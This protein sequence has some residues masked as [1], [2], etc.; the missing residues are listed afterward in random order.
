M[1]NLSVNSIFSLTTKRVADLVLEQS[2]QAFWQ[3]GIELDAK[4]SSIV[5]LAYQE[6][7]I[8]STALSEQTGLSRQLVELRLRRLVDDGYLDEKKDS[9]D[10][11]RRIYSISRK[12]SHD[13]ARAMEKLAE[14]EVIYR[15]IWKELGIDL[16]KGLRDL[17]S[18]LIAQPLA[19]RLTEQKPGNAA[20]QG[21]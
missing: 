14:F 2:R 20:K 3:S 18:T 8:T 16:Q 12:K 10:L 4:M 6:G 5:T 17:E 9:T 21:N 13:V 11:R 15:A 7:K 1:N 19:T